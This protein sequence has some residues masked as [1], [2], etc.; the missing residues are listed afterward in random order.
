MIK[1]QLNSNSVWKTVNHFIKDEDKSTP[2]LI[3]N[4]DKVIK[5]PQKL[6]DHFT[7]FFRTRVNEIWKSFTKTDT[8]P[9]KF[10]ELLVNKPNN[11]FEMIK[12]RQSGLGCHLDKTFMGAQNFYR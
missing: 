11:T 6:V 3:I 2:N 1:W 5:S 7:R 12:L 10:L 8:D 9:I 4:E